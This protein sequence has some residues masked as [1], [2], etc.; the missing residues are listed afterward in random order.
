MSFWVSGASRIRR[1]RDFLCVPGRAPPAE[2]E[3]DEAPDADDDTQH[4]RSGKPGQS[5]QPENIAARVVTINLYREA[6]HAVEHGVKKYDLT[7]ESLAPVQPEQEEEDQQRT[8]TF[9]KLSRV[10]V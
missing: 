3:H 1:R 2:D 7:A 5:R 10:K 6:H 4:L 8:E 9:V